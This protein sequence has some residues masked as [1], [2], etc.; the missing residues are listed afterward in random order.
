MH[1]TSFKPVGKA[2]L[3]SQSVETAIEGAVRSGELA[4]GQ[5]LPSEMELCVQFGVS[6]TVLREALRMLSARGLL[7][8][9]K[10]R[11]IFVSTLSVDSVANPMEL[12]L[13]MHGG[14]GQAVDV[15]GVRQLIE[16]AVAAEAALRHTADDVVKLRANVAELTSAVQS[17]ERMT[18]LDMSFHMLIAEAAHNRIL[19]LILRPVQMLMPGIKAQVYDV[20]NDAHDTA[21]YWHSRILEAILDRDAERARAEMAGH[22]EIAMEHVRLATG[23]DREPA[24]PARPASPALRV[25]ESA[26]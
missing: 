1:S 26:G 3:L 5:K 16:P 25:R 23:R 20:V 18:V 14:G 9:E 19:P 24:A 2:E 11:G 7:R 15:V 6:R 17:H 13:H 22:L 8:I 4:P 10:G 21:V 12:Y